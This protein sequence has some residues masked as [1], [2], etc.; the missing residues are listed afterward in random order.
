VRNTKAILAFVAALLAL[1]VFGG[2]VYAARHYGEVRLMDALIAVPVAFALAL[3]SVI[4]GRRARTEHRRTLGR[5][6]SRG[7]IAVTRL[8]GTFAFLLALT[9]ALALA[10]FGVLVLVE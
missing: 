3:A 4:L 8:L 9:A 6:G 2:A 1:A 5:S 10:V 7:F